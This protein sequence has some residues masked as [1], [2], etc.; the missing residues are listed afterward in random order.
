MVEPSFRA[1][2]MPT[3]GRAALLEPGFGAASGTAITLSVIAVFA[4]PEQRVASAAAANP[5]PEN[6]LALVRHVRPKTGLDNGNKSWQVGISLCGGLLEGCQTGTRPLP[7]AGFRTCSRLPRKTLHLAR[8]D[9]DGW[10]IAPAARMMLP[11]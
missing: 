2:L 1:A 3:V 9:D 5:L 6:R 4:D 11:V 7:T 10:M 8:N